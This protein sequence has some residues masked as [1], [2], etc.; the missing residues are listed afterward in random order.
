MGILDRAKKLIGNE[1]HRRKRE[2]QWQKSYHQYKHPTSTYLLT[3]RESNDYSKM[4][5]ETFDIW[6]RMDAQKKAARRAAAGKVVHRVGTKL[7]KAIKESGKETPHRSKRKRARIAPP[8]KPKG[9][10]EQ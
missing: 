4:E 9:W 1:V 2:A 7:A 3:G 6:S 8:R 10:W 5:R